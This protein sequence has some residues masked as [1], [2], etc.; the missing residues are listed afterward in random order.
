MKISNIAKA[1]AAASFAFAGQ[2]FA[3]APTVTPDLVVNIS[4][5]SAQQVTLGHLLTNFCAGDLDTY[6]DRP[7]SGTAGSAY[8][9]YFCTMNNAA[10]AALQGKRVLFNTRSRGGS[11]WGV[12]PVGKGW[13]VEYMNIG[14]NGGSH[15]AINAST[16]NY[17]CTYVNRTTAL[18]NGECPQD[19]A[20]YS[21][22]NRETLCARSDGGVSDVEP[23]MFVD[24]NLPTGWNALTSAELAGLTVNSEYGVIF[25]ISVTDDVYAALQ[26]AQGLAASEV[27][28][29]TKSQIA[30]I[31]RGDIR[32][33][34]QLDANLAGISTSSA[35]GYMSVCR[36]VN[37]SGTQASQNAY[38]FNTPCASAA[39]VADAMVAAGASGTTYRVVENS[40]SGNVVDCMNRSFS[41]G[42]NTSAPTLRYG[43]IGFGAIERQPGASDHWKYVKI[44]GVEPTVDNTISTAYDHVYEQTIQWQSSLSGDKLAALQMVLT[45][46]GD[47]A[48]LTGA[49][50]TG[51][52]ALQANG[53][54]WNDPA[55]Y[56]TT[57]GTR[58]GNS[59]SSFRASR[60]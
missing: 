27:P 7:A 57:R 58:G 36:R 46:S 16:H 3:L 9:S 5:A 43:G 15:C 8:R 21:V 28:S 29:L 44:D 30:G 42:L 51:V 10:P 49:G 55:D 39:G 2:A 19:G 4:G 50:V 53:N 54:D 41:G 31:L 32:T 14:Y 45:A 34:R 20:D 33:W 38:F 6:F 40:S 24:S 47:P 37:G 25:G 52:V 26:L 35:T 56:P 23:A 13:N 12:V 1:V 60:Y 17:E 48:V 59:C 22:A 11:V 18:V